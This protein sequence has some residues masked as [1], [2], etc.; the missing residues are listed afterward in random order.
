MIALA[1]VVLAGCG[2]A[3]PKGESTPDPDD[4]GTAPVVDS[5]TTDSASPTTAATATTGTTAATATTA[6]TAM[7]GA[8][9]DT[10]G[11]GE[12]GGYLDA[13]LPILETHCV[14]CHLGNNALGGFQVTGY[15][16]L[17][18]PSH[19]VPTM[20]RVDAAGADPANSYLFLK[21]SGQHLA[22]GG[23]GDAMP[24]PG[25]LSA[26]QRAVIEQWILRGAPR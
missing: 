8:T 25:G 16:S 7:T 4:T 17:L 20:P 12:P 3:A 26:P 23:A 19:D 18:A 1:V 6:T 5:G 21:V 15:A 13:I 24:A 10:G 14:Y 9:A 11:P 2:D 22:A